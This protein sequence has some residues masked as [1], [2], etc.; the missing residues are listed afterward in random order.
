MHKG[1]ITFFNE[2]VSEDEVKGKRIIE[3][4]SRNINGSVRPVF[5]KYGCEVYIGLDIIE[6]EGV[7][8]ICDVEKDIPFKDFDIVIATE[9]LEHTK[10]WQKVVSNFKNVIKENGLFFLTTRSK[11]FPLH[12]YP[13][14]FHRFEVEDIKYIFSDCEIIKLEIDPQVPGVFMKAKKPVNFIEKDLNN[15]KV[16]S[17]RVGKEV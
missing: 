17:V 6:G 1:I 7:D 2:N 5:E 4:G 8:V 16:Y 14:D 3:F 12:E 11:G 15:Y 10:N 13:S 9:L